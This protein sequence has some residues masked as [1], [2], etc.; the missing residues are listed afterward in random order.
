MILYNTETAT[1]EEFEPREPGRVSMYVC[2]PTVYAP[3][4]LGHARTAITFDVV[5]KWLEFDGYEV[6]FVSNFTD[7]DDKII[8]RAEYE[9][10]EASE[11]A[12]RY[13]EVWNDA[14]ARLRVAPPDLS[15]HATEYVRLMVEMIALL[16]RR[17][18]AYESGGDVYFAVRSFAPYGRLSHHKLE[19]LEAGA[20][21]EPGENK[22]DP[23]DFA[24]WKAAKAGE[25]SWESPWGPGRPGWHI[26]CSVMASAELGMGFDIH[27]G[28]CDLVFPHH[29]NEI[30][31]AEA[32]FGVAPFTRYWLHSG[33]VN[34]N[35]EKMAK[36]T[37]NF[38]SL[39][40]AL[41]SHSPEAIRLLAIQTHYR[42]PLDFADELIEDAERAVD[43]L[44]LFRS[45][46][47]RAFG[48]TPL[49]LSE[50]PEVVAA[51]PDPETA[52][53]FRAA[54]R[55]D[56][57]TPGAL[58]ALFEMLKRANSELDS[59]ETGSLPAYVAALY[60]VDSVFG[61]LPVDE[62]AKDAVATE[63]VDLI[64]E[65]RVRARADRDF[66]TADLIRDRLTELEIIVEDTPEGSLWRRRR[67]P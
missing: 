44:V 63:L 23:L 25:P 61:I 66:E 24:L 5:R 14:M 8:Q 12:A 55:D 56:F 64:L 18:H 49:L 29:E 32:A 27:G 1:L 67:R 26:E 34:L 46:A 30:A 60:D 39:D 48:A 4:H 6:T 41:A 17:G 13:E 52:A 16:E 38:L 43:R 15:P 31:Q 45:R 65:L 2:G 21:V 19:D 10:S 28:G 20:R 9:R 37:G 53:A 11:I 57:H 58:A 51:N 50:V 33:M 40:D 62:P 3:P 36:S 35:S 7:V 54:M 59:G 47:A 22:H 42:S